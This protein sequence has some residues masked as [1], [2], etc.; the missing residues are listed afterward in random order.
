MNLPVGNGFRRMLSKIACNFK[1]VHR[2]T[3]GAVMLFRACKL[4]LS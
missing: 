3:E 4:T 2:A 1:N